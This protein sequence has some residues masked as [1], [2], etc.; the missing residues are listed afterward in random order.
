[1]GELAL[2]VGDDADSVGKGTIL[3]FSS[4]VK[5]RE[6]VGCENGVEVMAG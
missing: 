4:F 3:G 5:G 2:I 6:A 1:M